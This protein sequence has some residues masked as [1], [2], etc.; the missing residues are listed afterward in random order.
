M[1]ATPVPLVIDTDP[2]VDDLLAII[3]ALGSPEVSL[4]AITLSFGNTTLD[5][6]YANIQRIA[7][8]LK[9]TAKEGALNNTVLAERVEHGTHGKPIR[10]AMGASKPLGGR[11]F[12]ASYFHGRDGMSGVSFLPGNPFP[13]AE[14]SALFGSA[15][16]PMPAD[17][18]L[19]DI[20]KQHPPGTVRIAAVAP[21]TNLALAFLK[22]PVTFRRVG[23]IS[24]M[25][26]AL[27]LPGNTS[28][29]AEFN[30]FADPWAAKVLL[31]DAVKEGGYLPISLFP[32]DVTTLHTLPYSKLVRD[33]HDALYQKSTLVRL[34]SHFLRKPRAVTNSFAPPGTPFDAAKYDLFE[35]HDPLA[36]AHCI[37]ASAPHLEWKTA[38]RV[39][40][41]ETDGTRTRG[42]CVVDRRNHGTPI[43]GQNKAELEE[44]NGAHDEHG[45][46]DTKTAIAAQDVP[47]ANVATTTPGAAWF[48]E[49]FLERL[50]MAT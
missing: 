18:L 46:E 49:M 26:G 30:F 16:D 48:A 39:F 45:I 28:P 4:E 38:F 40:L 7:H 1:P 17:E 3:L 11:M 2:G 37:F 41:L 25:G 35:A 27:D 43:E 31:E 22:D 9:V 29:V 42:F 50:G 23:M 19:L 24:V 10:V 14:S 13:C 12:T 47:G 21:L 36:I 20:L 34:I 15:P 32:L 6:A 33:E 44:R 8:A 5:Y